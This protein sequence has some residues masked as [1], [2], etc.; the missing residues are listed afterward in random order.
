MKG[1]IQTSAQSAAFNAGVNCLYLNDG[2]TKYW[3]PSKVK[4]KSGKTAV[5]ITDDA[6]NQPML[7]DSQS[8]TIKLKD[9]PGFKLILDSLGGA[10]IIEIPQGDLDLP[11]AGNPA[12]WTPSTQAPALRGS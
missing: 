12:Q 8:D 4:L 5:I 2:K 11:V 6:L 7:P 10:P 3:E 1:I 9:L